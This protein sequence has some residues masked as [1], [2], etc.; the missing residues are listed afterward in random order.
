MSRTK[1]K[2]RLSVLSISVLRHFNSN[3]C[4]T[5]FIS[6]SRWAEHL[7][8]VRAET[9]LAWLL[10]LELRCYPLCA[11]EYWQSNSLNSDMPSCNLI[12]VSICLTQF[13]SKD[14]HL[15][16]YQQCTQEM[17]KQMEKLFTHCGP[18]ECP[19][20]HHID[21]RTPPKDHPLMSSSTG[22]G[23]QWSRGLSVM[24]KYSETLVPTP[25]R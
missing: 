6:Y 15:L 4:S 21:L 11:K 5:N 9:A 1:V 2:S 19:V 7:V 17:C 14:H 13:F 20:F 24:A 23:Q 25:L 22:G 3:C 16:F 8:T 12:R 18:S 10:H